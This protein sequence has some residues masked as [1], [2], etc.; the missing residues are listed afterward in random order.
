MTE[1]L[2]NHTP[3]TIVVDEISD[4]REA[5][6]CLDIKERGVR[7]V[8]SAHGDF[9]SLLKSPKLNTLVGGKTSVIVGDGM[10][11]ANGGSK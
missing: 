4:D 3:Q 7:V 8:A 1:A 2:Q 11:M 10:A 5:C 6:A 9:Q